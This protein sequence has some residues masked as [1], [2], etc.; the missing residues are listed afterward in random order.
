VLL[1][2]GRNVEALGIYNQVVALEVGNATSWC[3]RATALCSLGR[4]LEA[5]TSYEHAL[6]LNSGLPEAW[7]GMG[8]VQYKVGDY[9]EALTCFKRAL[10]LGLSNASTAISLAQKKAEEKCSSSHRPSKRK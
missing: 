1:K 3:M 7:F 2:L 5:L 9:P 6:K 10:E 4:F 8:V